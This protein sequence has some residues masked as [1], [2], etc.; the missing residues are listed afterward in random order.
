MEF[1][2][3]LN[4]EENDIK[5]LKEGLMEKEAI[6]TSISTKGNKHNN[7]NLSISDQINQKINTIL[8]DIFEENIREGLKF[9]YDFEESSFQR[10]LIYK[11]MQTSSE[12]I[13]LLKNDVKKIKINGIQ[14]TFILNNNNSLLI[15]DNK[16]AEIENIPDSQENIDKIL[17]GKK[18]H[19]YLRKKLRQMV[20]LK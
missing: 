18:Y 1:T 3:Y 5:K 2:N 11:K 17:C 13:I 8:G 19:F 12:T 14:Y 6:S 10:K 20:F 15:K 4:N 16:K 9:K 7:E